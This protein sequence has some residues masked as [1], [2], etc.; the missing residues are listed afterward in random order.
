[1]KRNDIVVILAGLSV[2]ILLIVAVVLIRTEL[3]K[4]KLYEMQIQSIERTQEAIEEQKAEE[5]ERK[6][7]EEDAKWW[8]KSKYW[9]PENENK[10]IIK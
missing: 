7:A 8:R 5:E 10:E 3:M 1:M 6:Q 4:Q 9:N 2:F